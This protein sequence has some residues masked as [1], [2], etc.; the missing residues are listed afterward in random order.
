MTLTPA[1]LSNPPIQRRKVFLD[2][3]KKQYLSNSNTKDLGQISVDFT[4]CVADI[5]IYAPVVLL[6]PR[7]FLPSSIRPWLFVLSLNRYLTLHLLLL[8]H[9]SEVAQVQAPIRSDLRSPFGRVHQDV[10]EI[11]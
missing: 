3:G 8:F 6:G 4:N 2:M 1:K 5:K 10:Q 9:S 11:G 7:R